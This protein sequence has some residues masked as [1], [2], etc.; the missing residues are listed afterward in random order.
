[1]SRIIINDSD[2]MLTA[3]ERAKI[4]KWERAKATSGWRAYPSTCSAIFARIPPSGLTSIPP[5]SWER[6]PPCSNPHMTTAYSMAAT[7][8]SNA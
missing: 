4:A 1:M 8:Q 6:S 3:K 7:M 5:S 2:N